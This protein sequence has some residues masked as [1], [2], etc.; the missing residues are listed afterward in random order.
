MALVL[1]MGNFVEIPY[2]IKVCRA[3][4]HCGGAEFFLVD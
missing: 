4:M 1:L 3:G 2:Y